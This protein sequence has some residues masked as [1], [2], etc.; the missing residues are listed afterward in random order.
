M[1]LGVTIFDVIICL[2]IELF[3]TNLTLLKPEHL[4]LLLPH[5]LWCC[6][7]FFQFF[8]STSTL[9]LCTLQH[10]YLMA[11]WSTKA[12][13]VGLILGAALSVGCLV[14]LI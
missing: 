11:I 2:A 13:P 10:A 3:S 8:V 4:D 7:S 14:A 1:A 5:F 9:G 6:F 12:S